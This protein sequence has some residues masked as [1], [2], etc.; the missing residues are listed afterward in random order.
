MMIISWVLPKYVFANHYSNPSESK[1]NKS[2]IRVKPMMDKKKCSIR[3]AIMISKFLFKASKMAHPR[4]Y[5]MPN[6]DPYDAMG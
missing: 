2:P 3:V 1:T 6:G 4:F 5:P